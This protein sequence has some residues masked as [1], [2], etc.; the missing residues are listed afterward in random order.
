MQTFIYISFLLFL[1]AFIAWRK[2]KANKRPPRNKHP[3]SLEEEKAEEK[4]KSQIKM[5]FFSSGD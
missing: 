2:Y 5:S 4:T 3:K 1:F